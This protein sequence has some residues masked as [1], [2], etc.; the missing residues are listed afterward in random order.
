MLRAIGRTGLH[1][2]F[3]NSRII[4]RDISL[5]PGRLALSSTSFPHGRSGNPRGRRKGARNKL[6]RAFLESLADDFQYHGAGAIEEM[7]RRK[8][9]RYLELIRSVLPP[10]EI[11][12]GSR[13]RG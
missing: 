10:Q 5:G 4:Q 3:G 12:L 11:I 7:R 1:D 6:T 13:K 2:G 9:D 8:P